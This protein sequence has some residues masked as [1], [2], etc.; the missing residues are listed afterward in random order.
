MML[1]A[2]G[3]KIGR[4]CKHIQQLKIQGNFF[5]ADQFVQDDVVEA[6]HVSNMSD[7]I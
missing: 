1:V 7:V 5:D 3:F 6:C 4:V 2:D